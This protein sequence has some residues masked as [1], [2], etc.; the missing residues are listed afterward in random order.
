MTLRL[1]DDVINVISGH[2][3]GLFYFFYLFF[4]P[5]TI[6]RVISMKTLW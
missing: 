5:F 3:S 4:N 2:I 6:L 1:I